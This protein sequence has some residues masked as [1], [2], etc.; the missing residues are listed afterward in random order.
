M[1]IAVFGLGYVG[2]V[3]LVCLSKLGHK[4]YGCDVDLRKVNSINQGKSPILEPQIDDMLISGLSKGLIHGT[5][6]ASFCIENTDI[7]LIC[8]GTPID[9]R[10]DVNLNDV[11]MVC[12]SLA[13][14]LKKRVEKYTLVLRSTIPPGTIN[15]IILPHLA[16][17]LGK[18]PHKE[19]LVFIPEFLREGNAVNDFFQSNRLVMGVANEK[20]DV[21]LVK[22]LFS[23]SM[24]TPFVFTDY[25]TAELIKYVDNAYH[26]IKVAFVNEIY[27]LGSKLGADVKRA[28][29][30]FLMDTLLNISTQYLKPG[31]PFGGSC[32]TKDTRAIV[33]LGA[34]ANLRMPL[35][36]S[37]LVSNQQHQQ[38][39]LEKVIELKSQKILIYGLTFKQHTDDIR[40]SPFLFLLMDLL[41]AGKNVKVFDSNLN[42]SMLALEYPTIIQYIEF[43]YRYLINWA[44]IIVMNYPNIEQ[45]LTDIH[46]NTTIILNCFDNLN[47]Q[48]KSV[49]NLF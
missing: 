25:K 32:L 17:I 36:E 41:N 21:S 19:N 2:I 5:T 28:N 39:L 47:Y 27:T 4:I 20:Q 8:V 3:N 13:N 12:T 18:S 43:D 40:E 11:L 42:L 48:H 1:N 35:L 49:V 14:H 22:A 31:N 33:K 24:N 10:G 6:N 37:I 30:I 15:E 23:E 45:L 38:R 46:P 9:E 7:A 16:F 34:K 26:A 44:D 29:D